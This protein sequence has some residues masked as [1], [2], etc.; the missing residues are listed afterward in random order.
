MYFILKVLFD[1]K[2]FD[3]YYYYYYYIGT[4]RAPVTQ[5]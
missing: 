5:Q 4:F 3:Y 1:K 2:G